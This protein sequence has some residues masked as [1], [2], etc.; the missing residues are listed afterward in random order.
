MLA[1]DVE[2][3][4]GLV[5]R[6]PQ[7]RTRCDAEIDDAIELW[8]AMLASNDSWVDAPPN[9]RPSTKGSM[10]TTRETPGAEASTTV[11]RPWWLPIS[12][13]VPAAPTADAASQRSLA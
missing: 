13:I 11:D 1:V 9:S 2:E 6:R 3:V 4:D 8:F 7:G 10:A 5:P 12:T